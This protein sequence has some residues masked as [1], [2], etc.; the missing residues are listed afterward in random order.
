MRVDF[1]VCLGIHEEDYSAEKC[2]FQERKHV[3]R[4]Q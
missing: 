3:Q 2:S 1:V 4:G